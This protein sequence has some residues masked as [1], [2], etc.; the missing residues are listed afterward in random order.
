MVLYG[1][2]TFCFEYRCNGE[3]DCDTFNDLTPGSNFKSIRHLQLDLARW[4]PFGPLL[5]VDL[6]T[7][8]KCIEAFGCSLSSLRLNFTSMWREELFM[9]FQRFSTESEVER[10]VKQLCRLKIENKIEIEL[11]T[12]TIRDSDYERVLGFADAITAGR[13]WKSRKTTIV[14]RSSPHE[15]GE[16]IGAGV[17]I[18]LSFKEIE[19]VGHHEDPASRFGIAYGETDEIVVDERTIGHCRWR[20]LL[21]ERS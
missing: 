14:C 10:I 17:P 13:D 9:Q 2:N 18:D 19:R 21:Q 20:W 15:Q 4:F 12:L 16:D 3:G 6:E 7:T 1:E 11:V 8:L 5:P